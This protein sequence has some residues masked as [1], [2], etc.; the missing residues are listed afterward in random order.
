M[1]NTRE[2]AS[3]LAFLF[4][5]KIVWKFDSCGTNAGGHSTFFCI[6]KS[7]SLQI[8]RWWFFNI[9][10]CGG[11]V[12]S[13]ILSSCACVWLFRLAN[14]KIVAVW[15]I[16]SC[17]DWVN[18]TLVQATLTNRPDWNQPSCANPCK[19]VWS[20]ILLGTNALSQHHRTLSGLELGGMKHCTPAYTPKGCLVTRLSL[21]T[22]GVYSGQSPLSSPAQRSLGQGCFWVTSQEWQTPLSSIW[23]LQ[24]EMI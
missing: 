14:R 13:F 20:H 8:F 6:M 21:H 15:D 4:I 12:Y 10:E 1:A 22:A 24:W 17:G 7:M 9:R 16:C 11:C 19:L 3:P 23:Y 18:S 5:T 2:S